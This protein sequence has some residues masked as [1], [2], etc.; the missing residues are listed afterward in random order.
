M[1]KLECPDFNLEEKL[2]QEQ[3]TFFHKNG[4]IIFRNVLKKETVD[5]FIQEVTR[6][7]NQWLQEGRDKVNGVPLK[8][9]EDAQGQKMIQR[10]CFLSLDR[11]SLPRIPARPEDSGSCSVPLSIRRTYCRK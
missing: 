6:I 5:F 3:L 11:K 9:G 7:E 8:F 2:T 10:L 1:K 4:V